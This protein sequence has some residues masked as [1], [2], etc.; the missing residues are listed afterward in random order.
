MSD[1]M[2]MGLGCVTALLGMDRTTG[3]SEIVRA[4]LECIAYQIA[5]IVKAMEEDAGQKIEVLRVDG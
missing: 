1:Q 3:R 4:A 5:D 2:R